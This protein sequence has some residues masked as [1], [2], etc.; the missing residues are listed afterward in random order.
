MGVFRVYVEHRDTQAA[1]PTYNSGQIYVRGNRRV[2]EYPPQM[3]ANGYK[4]AAVHPELP[5]DKLR[6]R[7]EPSRLPFETTAQAELREGFIGQERELRA[8]KMGVELSAP[9][10]NM[11][12]CRLA[13]TMRA[14]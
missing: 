6:W 2:L 8:V 13:A 5:P 1:L 10:Y 11:H 12:V 3:S 14:G 7:C 9:G 4:P